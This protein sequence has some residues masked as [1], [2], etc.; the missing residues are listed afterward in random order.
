V[1]VIRSTGPAF[2][3]YDFHLFVRPKNPKNEQWSGP[4]SG[5]DAARDVF[6]ADG[7][8][9]IND[10]E[11]LLPSLLSEDG[12]IHLNEETTNPLLM[13][14]IISILE[15]AGKAHLSKPAQ[16]IL[17]HRR[18]R[19]SAAEVANMRKAGQVSGRAITRAMDRAWTEEKE[20]ASFL[21]AQFKRHNCDG[22]AYVP[23]VA[24]GARGNMIHYVRN[25]AK[26]TPGELV[27]VDAGGEYGNYITDITRTW[28]VSGKFT[29]AQRDLYEAVLT[30]QRHVVSLC[31]AT[32]CKTLDDLHLI[33]EDG[34]R[35]ALRALGF[36][37]SGDAINVLFPHHVGHY[38]GLDVHDMPGASRKQIL[39]P[40]HCITVEPGVYVPDDE[41]WPKHFRGMA[42][43]I[44]DSL[45]V[46]K[47][48]P[49]IFTTE[50]VKE[51]ADIEALRD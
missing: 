47:H 36:D 32:S 24:G 41:R 16:P 34:L 5:V 4:F 49:I 23:V 22:S 45:C 39:G 20:L 40:G 13:K 42:V 27:L 50:A 29:P 19:K 31:A 2:D 28:P 9:D 38:I 26:L 11:R 51:V 46:E 8:D 30:V 33:T 21:D 3:D 43:R 25:D 44:E 35:E 15:T 7:A 37:M 10:L 6:N 17:H 1:A 18:Q 14:R 48:A 12:P